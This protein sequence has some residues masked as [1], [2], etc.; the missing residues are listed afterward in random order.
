MDDSRGAGC[1]GNY[2]CQVDPVVMDGYFDIFLYDG[3]MTFGA[4][5]LRCLTFQMVFQATFFITLIWR[6]KMKGV[7]S[8]FISERCN[9]L[10]SKSQGQRDQTRA[11]S[12]LGNTLIGAYAWTMVLRASCAWFMS[13]QSPTRSAT[14]PAVEIVSNCVFQRLPFSYTV[15]GFLV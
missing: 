13:L 15:C 1:D 8:I 12:W 3:L 14:M 7:S 5:C 11:G 6:P 10:R 2:T 9:W 4:R